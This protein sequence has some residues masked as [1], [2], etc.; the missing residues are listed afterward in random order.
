MSGPSFVVRAAAEDEVADC[1]DLWVRAVASRDGRPESDAVRDR[2]AAKFAADRVVLLVAEDA[3]GLAG[4]VL[5]TAPRTG[6]AS[7]PADAAYLSL[8]AVAPRTQG[9]GVGRALLDEA[10]GAAARAGHPRCVLHALDDNVPAL[11]LY[12]GAGFRPSDEPF[13]HPVSGRPTRVWTAGG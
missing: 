5:V 12:R 1:T 7:D 9:L 8:L 3:D 2:A 13:P 6:G 4:F 11:R 10:V